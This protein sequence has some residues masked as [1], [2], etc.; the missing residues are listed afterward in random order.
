MTSGQSSSSSDYVNSQNT[1][2][3]NQAALSGLELGQYQTLLPQETALSQAQLSQSL[4]NTNN[5]VYDWE[6]TQ[7]NNLTSEMPSYN[8]NIGL[9]SP[10]TKQYADLYNNSLDATMQADQRQL[11]SNTAAG[12]LFGSSYEAG[13]QAQL[14]NL[15][16]QNEAQ[17]EVTAVNNAQSGQSN[18]LNGW[19]SLMSTMLGT[20]SYSTP[21][22]PTLP[23]G[24]SNYG[25]TLNSMGLNN[26]MGSLLG[27]KATSSA[28]S[29]GA[30]S[31]G[32]ALGGGSGA[33]TGAGVGDAAIGA[34]E[35]GADMSAVMDALPAILT[36]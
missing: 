36:L 30:G 16:A 2:L 27:S 1:L 22:A 19:T 35:G 10:E 12:N 11:D 5:P 26:M 9:N 3:N 28:L 6:R 23:T 20:P 32:S 13:N 24:S 15:K 4:A 14:S 34:A 18:N 21:S 7:S 17:N 25:S 31:I 8:S 29:Q 33:S